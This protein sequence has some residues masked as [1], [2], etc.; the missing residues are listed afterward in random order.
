MGDNA[1]QE[2][3]TTESRNAMTQELSNADIEIIVNAV[4]ANGQKQ[5]RVIMVLAIA[6]IVAII[7]LSFAACNSTPTGNTTTGNITTPS[8]PIIGTWE[9]IAIMSD[10]GDNITPYTGSCLKARANGSLEITLED[11][12]YSGTWARDNTYDDEKGSYYYR[13]YMDGD[14]GV[15]VLDDE[16]LMFSPT[17]ESA[18]VYQK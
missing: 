10:D 16:T 7:V 3:E 5:R 17:G 12:K 8:D 11:E 6:V 9:S 2:K 14:V 15:M 1:I 13:V 4:K 18:L